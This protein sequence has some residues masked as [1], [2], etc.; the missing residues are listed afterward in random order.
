MN[1]GISLIISAIF[2]IYIYLYHTSST[3]NVLQTG[4][5]ILSCLKPLWNC[6]F[7]EGPT[8]AS[9]KERPLTVADKLAEAVPPT[10]PDHPTTKPKRGR[11]TAGDAAQVF[12][13]IKDVSKGGGWKDGKL[14]EIGYGGSGAYGLLAFWHFGWKKFEAGKRWLFENVLIM[15]WQLEWNM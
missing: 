12:F 4:P 10:A 8:L 14:D 11:G 7:F 2:D 3:V 13:W 6:C 5:F 1:H 15:L 9:F